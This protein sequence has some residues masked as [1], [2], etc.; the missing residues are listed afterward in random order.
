M[1]E[2]AVVTNRRA[3]RDYAILETL[4]A[5]IELR[6]TEVKSLRSHQASLNDG[7]AKVENGEVFL[8]NFHISPYKFGNINN[9]DPLRPKKLLLKKNQIA[10]LYTATKA[11][12]N[13]LVPLEVYFKNGLAKV[14]L[15]VG[16]GKKQ[17]DKREDIKAREARREMDRAM[18]RRGR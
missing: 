17:Y 13:T 9:P 11:K 10:G 2:K 4:E 1:T 14:S 5:G 18:R 6:G 7:F 16:R 15:A 12:G 3:R 8:Y